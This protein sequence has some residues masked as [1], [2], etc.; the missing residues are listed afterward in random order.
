[1]SYEPDGS[2]VPPW[3]NTLTRWQDLVG[4]AQLANLSFERLDQLALIR[5]LIHPHA[6]VTFGLTHLIPQRLALV[7]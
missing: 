1:M 5:C 3:R 6:L 7:H 4:L 2:R